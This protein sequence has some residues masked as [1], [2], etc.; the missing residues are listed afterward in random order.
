MSDKQTTELQISGRKR[1]LFLSILLLLIVFLLIVTE[2]FLYLVS[3]R[4]LA[5]PENLKL[6]P[7]G[8]P[9]FKVDKKNGYSVYTPTRYYRPWGHNFRFTMPKQR[10]VF[11]IFCLGGSAANG[12]AFGN[13]GAFPKWMEIMLDASEDGR[14]YEVI[15]SGQGGIPL[16]EVKLIAKRTLKADPDLIVIYSGNNEF[17]YHRNQ[18]KHSYRLPAPL[19]KTIYWL[20]E[21]YVTRLFQ[22]YLNKTIQR[23]PAFG[24]EEEAVLRH[25]SY[26]VEKQLDSKWDRSNRE[27]VMSDYRSDLIS[28]VEMA[29]E[30][31]ARVILCTV[32]VNLKDYEPVGS[33]HS[34]GL[35]EAEK[36]RWRQLV[37]KGKK[38]FAEND[39]IS[40]RNLFLKAASIDPMPAQLNFYLGHCFLRQEQNDGAY[41][42]FEKALDRDPLRNRAGTDLNAIVREVG[43][44]LQV[45]VADTVESFR[46]KSPEGVP[47]DDLFLDS[48]HPTLEGHRVIA[49]DIVETMTKTGLIKK[50]HRQPE[51]YRQACLRY[52]NKIPED[53]L[54]VSYMTAT[55]FNTYRGRFYMAEKCVSEALKY[56]PQNPQALHIKQTLESVLKRQGNAAN[57]PWGQIEFLKSY[58]NH[59]TEK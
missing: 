30:K 3:P 23:R 46:K 24:W 1:G 36:K 21:R 8:L 37:A 25:A 53:Y 7:I 59:N 27:K 20:K 35:S 52:Q 51:R 5:P 47:G 31:G 33:Y 12:G 40:A 9:Y 44:K 34:T 13:P 19:L 42:Y 41:K 22:Y 6:N 2:L 50:R 43:E 29:R 17:F 54:F 28:I 32:A 39:V 49:F 15:N 45:P 56:E 16:S 11:R 26:I 18:P 10:G 4:F 58:Q 55:S 48:V 38:E 14:K 57:L